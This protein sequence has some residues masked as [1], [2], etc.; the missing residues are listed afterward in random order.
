VQALL[1][2]S[3]L[4]TCPQDVV[5][6]TTIDVAYD[7]SRK[8]EYLLGQEDFTSIKEITIIP[9]YRFWDG[10]DVVTVNLE[11]F[12][13]NG[14]IDVDC[15]MKIPPKFRIRN[16]DQIWINLGYMLKSKYKC[17]IKHYDGWFD[18]QFNIWDEI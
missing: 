13:D 2:F 11:I 12:T 5:P 3:L 10:T 14:Y 6:P 15:L 4:S 17:E 16:V 8:L 7:V 9:R 18:K 1:L